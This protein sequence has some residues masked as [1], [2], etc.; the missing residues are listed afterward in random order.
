MYYKTLLGKE[1][2]GRK[3]EPTRREGPRGDGS[4]QT[5]AALAAPGPDSSVLTEAQ[6][7]SRS[8]GP[9]SGSRRDP[10]PSP[11]LLPTG[12]RGPGHILGRF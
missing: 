5:S 2:G 10:A 4:Q 6:Q 8:P 1:L 11:T 12:A 7:Q 9:G 3:Q